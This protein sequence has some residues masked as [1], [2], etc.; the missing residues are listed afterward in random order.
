MPTM[1]SAMP[2]RFSFSL[3]IGGVGGGTLPLGIPLLIRRQVGSIWFSKNRK[4]PKTLYW[5]RVWGLQTPSVKISL[6][7]E[8]GG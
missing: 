1:M 2:Q 6:M 5:C 8:V 3:Y 4:D 7:E